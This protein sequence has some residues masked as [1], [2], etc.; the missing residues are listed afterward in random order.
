MANYSSRNKKVF[1]QKINETKISEKI[2][3][4][5]IGKPFSNYSKAKYFKDYK[6]I[7]EELYLT[8]DEEYLSE[9]NYKF[10]T[11]INEILE[12]KQNLDGQVSLS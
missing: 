1:F 4:K 7:F 6:D 8:C 11:T 10:I 2:G 5:N 9:I 3:I 12:S